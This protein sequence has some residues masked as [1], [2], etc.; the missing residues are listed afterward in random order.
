MYRKCY[1]GKR[2]GENL[3]EMHLWESDGERQM[4]PYLNEAYQLCDEDQ[5]THQGLNG[6]HV[7]K[8]KKWKYSGSI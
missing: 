6:E 4:I 1:Q 2:I 7:R 8:I 5:S 3:Y